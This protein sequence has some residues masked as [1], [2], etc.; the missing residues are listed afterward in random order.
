MSSRNLLVEE[1]LGRDSSERP[2]SRRDNNI[3]M[4]LSEFCCEDQRLIE[5]THDTVA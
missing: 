2:R 4:D 5:T 3:K 1:C